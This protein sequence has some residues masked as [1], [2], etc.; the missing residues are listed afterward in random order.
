M[1]KITVTFPNLV[2]GIPKES[3]LPSS[4]GLSATCTWYKRAQRKIEEFS[5]LIAKHSTGEGM[6]ATGLVALQ[7]TLGMIRVL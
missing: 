6:S 2:L 5:F 4:L 1:W 7:G 3:F